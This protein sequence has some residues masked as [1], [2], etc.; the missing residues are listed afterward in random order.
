MTCKIWTS[1]YKLEPVSLYKLGEKDIEYAY[2]QTTYIVLN[3]LKDMKIKSLH[4][5][6]CKTTKELSPLNE[7]ITRIKFTML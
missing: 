4:I 5:F 6:N 3:K 7:N 1:N 2:L